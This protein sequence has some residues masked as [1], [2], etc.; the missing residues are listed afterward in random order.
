[1]NLDSTRSHAL[2]LGHASMH[3]AEPCERSPQDLQEAIEEL[4]PRNVAP[5]DWQRF[6]DSVSEILTAFGMNLDRPA[7]K[8]TPER[9][10]TALYEATAGYDGDH[11]LL[12]TFPT[13]CRCDA[14]CLANQ[15]IEGPIS[16]HALCEH[17]ALPFHGFAYVGYVS[18]K[19]IIG[20]SK[21]TRLV[22][23][24]ARR[25]TVQERLGEQVAG[26]LAEL[27]EPHGVGVHIEAAHLCTQM[28][29]VKEEQSRT[30]TSVWRG[31]HSEN[32]DLRRDF[33]AE[34]CRRDVGRH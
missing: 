29:G 27:L 11:K 20:I 25:F 9:L 14:D 23:L 32:P 17:H 10:L 16:F 31:S 7:T 19:R 1:M 6:Q 18:H 26:A 22:R 21:L 2:D 8:R 3:V 33:L 4:S 15:I 24:F 28:R 5:E 13:E 30:V 12:T 34:I